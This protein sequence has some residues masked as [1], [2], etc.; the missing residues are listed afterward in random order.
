MRVEI[1]WRVEQRYG[2]IECMQLPAELLLSH[3]GPLGRG[4]QPFEAV[5]KTAD[6]TYGVEAVA[7]SLVEVR[8]C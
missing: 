7:G 1:I 6:N 8:S 4:C 2:R 5:A 3:G